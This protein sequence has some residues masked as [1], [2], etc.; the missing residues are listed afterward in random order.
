[1]RPRNGSAE[2]VQAYSC[3]E[4]DSRVSR[5]VPCHGATEALPRIRAESLRDRRARRVALDDNGQP[6]EPTSDVTVPDAVGH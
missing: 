3:N 2:S 1:M 4:F 5:V 6:I